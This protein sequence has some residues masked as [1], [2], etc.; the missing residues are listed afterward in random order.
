MTDTIKTITY[1]L[2]SVIYILWIILALVFF[3]QLSTSFPLNGSSEFKGGMLLWIV[4]LIVLGGIILMI[5]YLI[6][7]K[8]L[9]KIFPISFFIISFLLLILLLRGFL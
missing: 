4:F 6:K 9:K 5:N 2:F 1:M 3:V 7:R 8:R